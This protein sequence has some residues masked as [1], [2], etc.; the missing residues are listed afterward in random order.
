MEEVP[1]F[2]KLFAI[3]NVSLYANIANFVHFEKNSINWLITV[4]ATQLRQGN[5]FTGVCQSFCLQGVCIP[6]CT[7]ADTP[8]V[9]MPPPGR[10]P[11]GQIPL[12]RYPLGRYPRADPLPWQ[13][14]PRA[15]P[16]R[17]PGQIPLVATAADGTHPTG[18]HSFKSIREVGLLTTC[19]EHAQRIAHIFGKQTPS[20]KEEIV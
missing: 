11:T 3:P 14:Q 2:A 7:W 9:D 6:A 15:D 1:S 12:G 8:W 20:H 10:H 5:I 4:S 18:M 16:P 17:P 13:T 19:N